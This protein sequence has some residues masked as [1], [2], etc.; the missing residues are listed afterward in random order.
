MAQFSLAN[1][2]FILDTEDDNDS[3]ASE[4]LMQQLRENLEVLFMLLLDTAIIG[5]ATEDPP[6]DTTGVLTDGGSPAMFETDEHNGR[7]LLITSG[8]A[9]NTIYTIDDT[10][11]TT[12]IC[13]DD[14]LYSA[15]VRSGDTYKVLYDIKVNTDGHD[16][17]GVNSKVL[18]SSV[19][20][21]QLKTS[22]G[23][24][25]SSYVGWAIK[26]LPG[27]EYGFYP[28]IKTSGGASCSAM[29]GYEFTETSYTTHIALS[30]PSGTGY[31]QQRY[32]TSSG[33]VHWIFVLRDKIT[34]DIISM[35]QAPDHPCFGN[36]GKPKLVEHPFG[37]YDSA[38]CEIIVVLPS[39][40]QVKAIRNITIKGENEADKDF[41]EAIWQVFEID[42]KSNPT[43]PT[44]KVTVGLPPDWD[45]AWLSQR[46]VRPIKKVIPKPDYVLC[47][48]L[49]LKA[50]K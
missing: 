46:P 33:E 9:K 10:T 28:Q 18:A 12:L 41:L 47:K 42:E 5:A 36:S 43:W 13:T 24:V 19:G 20:Q 14:N 3:P 39:K 16:H 32:V 7:T 49:K 44:E 38:K 30:V 6:D 2:R 21:T 29:L 40:E 37:N 26:T 1:L 50:G 34:K 4:E 35:W 17:D 8:I 45:D 15:G 25:S 48:S 23:S 31:A 11:T 22:T 27:G